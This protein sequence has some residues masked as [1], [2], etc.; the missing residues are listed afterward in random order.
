M[1]LWELEI[2]FRLTE[3]KRVPNNLPWAFQMELVLRTSLLM[4]EMKETCVRSLDQEDLLENEMATHSSILSWR[5]PWTEEPGRLQSM[6][7]QRAGHNWS[8]LTC[9]H[10]VPVGSVTSGYGEACWK[11]LWKEPC[12]RR[13]TMK[14]ILYPRI[15][16]AFSFFFLQKI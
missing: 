4:Q 14:N 13:I 5:I 12:E 8:D 6:G 2:L 11:C 1:K 16:T 9:M 15:N 7:L 10:A 3:I